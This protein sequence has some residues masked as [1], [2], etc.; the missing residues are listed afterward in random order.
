METEQRQPVW[1][2]ADASQNLHALTACVRD[3]GASALV[4]DTARSVAPDTP[5]PVAILLALEL[6][7]SVFREIGRL[8]ALCPGVPIVGLTSAPIPTMTAGPQTAAFTRVLTHAQAKVLLRHTIQTR[9]R[10]AEHARASAANVVSAVPFRELLVGAERMRRMRHR[11]GKSAA[12]LTIDI[13]RFRE[14]NVNHSID[15]GNRV[16]HWVEQTIASLAPNGATFAQQFSDRFVLLVEN[17]NGAE[18]LCRHLR[19]T[20]RDDAPL[21]DQQKLAVTATVGLAVS[22]TGWTESIETLIERSRTALAVG[23]MHGGNCHRVWNS[24]LEREY[25]RISR[26]TTQA[27]TGTNRSREFDLRFRSAQL[28]STLTLVAAVEARD[29]YTR[30]HSQKVALLAELIGRKMG[31]RPRRLETLR[32]AALLHD[33]GKVALPDSILLKP[34]PLTEYEYDRMRSHPRIAV[35]MLRYVS[36]FE[37]ERNIIL[38]HHERFDGK[39]Y[40]ARLAGDAIPI[41]ARILAVADTIDTILSRRTYKEP[42]TLERVHAELRNGAGSQFDPSVVDVALDVLEDHAEEFATPAAHT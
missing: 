12:I 37:N 1:V 22:T 20:L 41:G 18:R 2:I 32:A 10:S 24:E 8:R 21:L 35:E 40:P 30:S 36:H 13:D 26:K 39:G 28:E 17:A 6:S 31:I 23:K 19:E 11:D 29:P 15:A 27:P 42:H 34:G 5:Q 9:D 14:C 38:H 33:I 3:I 25:L 7:T 4:V 16:L